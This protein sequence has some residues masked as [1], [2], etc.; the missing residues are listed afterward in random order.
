MKEPNSKPWFGLD[1]LGGHS[2]EDPYPKPLYNEK[3][4]ADQD[5][6]LNNPEQSI[7]K[8]TDKPWVQK[9]E[10]P[11]SIHDDSGVNTKKDNQ[12]PPIDNWAQPEKRDVIPD[13]R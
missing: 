2:F 8:D 13:A 5:K 6:A 7:D 11:T 3:N 12:D 10:R 9:I 1:D 4:T